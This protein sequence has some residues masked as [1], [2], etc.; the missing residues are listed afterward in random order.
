MIIQIRGT[1]GSGKS[2]LVR[3]VMGL[4]DEVTS[5]HTEGRRQPAS[6]VL[7]ADGVQSLNVLGH[8]E[9]DCGG[10][11]TLPSFDT[12]FAMAVAGHQNG[13]NVLM[14]GVLLYCE[15]ART[16]VLPRKDLLVIGLNTPLDVCVA[17]IN[18][19]RRRK[20]PDAEAVDP[21]NTEAK[22][23][24]TVSYM[25]KLRAAGIQA[26]WHNRET[27]YKRLI[28]VLGLNPEFILL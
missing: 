27:A 20:K 4:Y 7:R 13:Y 18:E 3:R 23:R 5:I 24:G 21:A 10:C 6:Y 15:T 2:T 1:S 28:E 11:D 17:G 25:E 22:H 9:T 12:T 19:R 8:Y 26:E 14:E 16:F